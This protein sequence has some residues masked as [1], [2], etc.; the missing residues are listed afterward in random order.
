MAMALVK[1]QPNRE[2]AMSKSRSIALAGL[3]TGMFVVLSMGA[4]NA[5]PAPTGAAA[6]LSDAAA[7]QI[8]DVQFRG[9]RGGP[10]VGPRV[11]RVYGGPR[12]YARRGGGRG[13]AIGAGIAA[14]VLGAVIGSA[15]MAQQP[16]YAEPAPVYGAPVYGGGPVEYC[17]RRYRSYNPNTGTYI[18]FDGLER[19]C[20]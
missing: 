18:G 15:I 10:R 3:A 2:I 11:G 16:A 4:A 9:M 14:G 7:V 8:E 17:M 13:A 19:P 20:P 1:E 6:A 5:G 12:V